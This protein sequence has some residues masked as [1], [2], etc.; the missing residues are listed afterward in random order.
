MTQ[1]RRNKL[2]SASSTK[3]LV[4]TKE[5]NTS[6]KPVKRESSIHSS[7]ELSDKATLLSTLYV[8]EAN[9]DKLEFTPLV[10][11]ID[12]LSISSKSP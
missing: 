4:V 9:S 1:R 2:K 3:D 6:M 8:D 10:S 7:I 12:D 11:G 5:P